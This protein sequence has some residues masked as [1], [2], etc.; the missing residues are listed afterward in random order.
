MAE[1]NWTSFLL[2]RNESIEKHLRFTFENRKPGLHESQL[3]VE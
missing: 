1:K 3:Q 2:W